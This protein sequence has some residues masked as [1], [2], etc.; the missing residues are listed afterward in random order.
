MEWFAW[1]TLNAAMGGLL[2]VTAFLL[3][4]FARR[5]GQRWLSRWAL[6]L[7][8]M[9]GATSTAW[10]IMEAFGRSPFT[11]WIQLLAWV[12]WLSMSAI[13]WLGMVW[14]RDTL[15]ALD[16]IESKTAAV[17]MQISNGRGLP[18]VVAPDRRT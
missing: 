18:D 9:V 1:P 7:A 6:L 4:R 12:R 17:A 5:N 14:M 2:T 13:L 8:V 3:W 11:L 10:P 16:L 15:R